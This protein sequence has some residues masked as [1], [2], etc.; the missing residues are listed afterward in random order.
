MMALVVPFASFDSAA[1][2]PHENYDLMDSDIDLVVSMLNASIRASEDALRSFHDQNLEVAQG[3]I[4]MATSVVDP[5]AAILDQI[6]DVAASHEQLAIL[7]PPFTAFHDELQVF[8]ELEDRMLS[9][10]N[11][12]AAIAAENNLSDSDAIAVVDSIREMNIVLSAMN[13]TIAVML[14]CAG[15]INSLTIDDIYPFLPNDLAELIE[16]LWDLTRSMHEDITEMIEEDIPWQ[17]DEPF[18][19][20]WI[21]DSEIYLGEMLDGG[22]YL[23]SS[24]SFV[25]DSTIN[26]SIDGSTNLT[27]HTNSGGAFSFSF[28]V[29]VN[30]S[31]LGVHNI[32]ATA[33][34]SA[35]AVTSDTLIFTVSLVPTTMTLLLSNTTMS[36]W[37]ELVVEATL[38]QK[39]ALPLPAVT[40]TLSV[41]G[42]DQEF[43]TD[44]AGWSEWIWNGADLGIGTHVFSASFPG[45]LPYAAC[46]SD[47]AT[48]VVDVPTA[49]ALN[50]FTDR[51][52]IGWYLTGDGILTANASLPL[53][54]KKIALS[55]D[56]V[57]VTNVSTDATGKFAFSIDTADLQAG[58]HILSAQFIDSGS[59]WRSSEDQ[60]P[61]Y[62]ISLSYSDYPFLPWIPGWDIGG[63]LTE[64]IP[65]LFFGEYAYITWLFIVLVIGVV[66]KALQARQRKS[67][68]EAGSEGVSAEGAAPASAVARERRFASRE[69]MPDWLTRPNEKIIWHYHNLLAFLKTGGRIGITDNLTHWEVAKLLA[70]LGY[71]H[72]ETSRI[73]LL[74]ER[75]QY[76]GH[77]SSEDDV[78]EMDSSSSV[79]KRSGGVRPAV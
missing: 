31:W 8:L 33:Q 12:I 14:V 39:R 13:D 52:R 64:Q 61:F 38:T 43:T 46:E 25:A 45:L 36:P 15:D 30:S 48:V 3:Y 65:Y 49:I 71:P 68:S 73:A 20:L 57:V 23:L 72:V 28:T 51:L 47:E 67:A 24:G 79:L 69:R 50:L 60:V 26:V 40:C 41:D 37:D 74:Y 75:A 78:L 55:I 77:D 19:L 17:E 35:E 54:D 16:R 1:E 70:A 42:V 63:G 6:E 21:A 10:K 18:L 58:T 29:P 5:A 62:I 2:I 56:G 59:Y 53:G 11:E 32:M 22:G 27:T 34:V 4:D 66:I 7:I 9:V 76:S 44:G